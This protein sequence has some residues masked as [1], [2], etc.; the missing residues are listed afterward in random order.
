MIFLPNKTTLFKVR[1]ILRAVGFIRRAS[2]TVRAWGPLGV[3]HERSFCS[4]ESHTEEH[5]EHIYWNMARSQDCDNV[6]EV[7]MSLWFHLRVPFLLA[8]PCAKR[9]ES[10]ALH[11]KSYSSCFLNSLGAESTLWLIPPERREYINTVIIRGF[12][13]TLRPPPPPLLCN[14]SGCSSWRLR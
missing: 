5:G 12:L 9:R 1:T 2:W 10:T 14:S 6:L 7:L 11:F 3:L 8:A 4:A 13:H